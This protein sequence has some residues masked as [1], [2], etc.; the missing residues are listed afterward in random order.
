MVWGFVGSL[1]C[2]SLIYILPPAFYLRVRRHPAKPDLKK[3][4]AILLLVTGIFLLIAGAYQSVMN[5]VSPLPMIR[6][7]EN[8]TPAGNN[9]TTQWL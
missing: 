6:L 1:G 7:A 8:L 3:I 2:T 9:K 4:S 5:I